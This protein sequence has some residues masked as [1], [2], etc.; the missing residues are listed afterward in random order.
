[1][2]IPPPAADLVGTLALPQYYSQNYPWP[3]GSPAADAPENKP[4]GNIHIATWDA[5]MDSRVR[6]LPFDFP[7]TKEREKRMEIE[8]RRKATAAERRTRAAA[9]KPFT[10]L[11]NA[12]DTNH[13]NAWKQQNTGVDP[14]LRSIYWPPASSVPPF[15]FDSAAEEYMND[16]ARPSRRS[17]LCFPDLRTLARAFL[18]PGRTSIASIPPA[19]AGQPL[20]SGMFPAD[21][22]DRTA[23]L[24]SIRFIQVTWIDDIKCINQWGGGI[25]P[26]R[27]EWAIEAMEALAAAIADMTTTKLW[28]RIHFLPKRHL[29]PDLNID[30]PG[31]YQLLRLSARHMIIEQARRRIFRP[32]PDRLRDLIIRSVERGGLEK[33]HGTELQSFPDF[34]PQF[35]IEEYKKW[36]PRGGATKMKGR[37]Q[38][39]N[40]LLL[41]QYRKR[42]DR[43]KK[44]LQQSQGYLRRAVRRN[45]GPTANWARLLIDRVRY[46]EYERRQVDADIAAH[47][48]RHAPF[49]APYTLRPEEITQANRYL[50][51]V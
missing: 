9:D 40:E 19:V 43:K 23:K 12:I 51:V 44:L 1:M 30:S 21:G 4:P 37:I 49:F 26:H 13:L 10:G 14:P 18:P 36:G 46:L 2:A 31:I 7:A 32:L 38:K 25:P 50:P 28:I 41:R 8:K 48:G 16:I 11:T 3:R 33:P 29:A 5:W 22:P 45:D 27:S 47:K 17:V 24:Q 35:Q 42:Y 6:V 20:P 39:Q 34:G 15:P